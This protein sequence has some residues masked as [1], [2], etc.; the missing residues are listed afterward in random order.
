MHSCM[1]VGGVEIG[2]GGICSSGIDHVRREEKE[3]GKEECKGRGSGR[4]RRNGREGRRGGEEGEEEEVGEKG[5]GDIYLL[6][7]K[8][9]CCRIWSH[10]PGSGS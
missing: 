9:K 2:H 8:A 3:E 4:G 7:R 10:F 6:H 1:C 5:E